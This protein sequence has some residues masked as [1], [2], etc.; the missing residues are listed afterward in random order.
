MDITREIFK[1]L[2]YKDKLKFYYI[3]GEKKPTQYMIAKNM[4]M[5]KPIKSIRGLQKAALSGEF[6]LCV[7]YFLEKNKIFDKQ[8]YENY[9]RNDF[10]YYDKYQLSDRVRF[11]NYPDS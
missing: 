10:K 2:S 1:H 5:Y 3:F 7:Q 8:M 11:R 9:V 6:E 4:L